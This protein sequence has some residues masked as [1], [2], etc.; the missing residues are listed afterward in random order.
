MASHFYAN[1]KIDMW[2]FIILGP[3]II[4]W[5]FPSDEARQKRV[6]SPC[7]CAE[8]DCIMITWQEWRYLGN[9]R[10]DHDI[11]YVTKLPGAPRSA[12]G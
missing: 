9:H 12:C 4:P 10:S 7:L 8:T 1:E 11:L 6:Y 5:P 2:Y 3:R